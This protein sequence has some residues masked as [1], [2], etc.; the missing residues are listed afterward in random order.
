LPPR[1]NRVRE[2][3]TA[4]AAVAGVIVFSGSPLV[5]EVIA[6]AG[7]DFVILDME[8]SPLGLGEAAHLIR[9]ADASGITAFVRIPA[10]D[11]ALV[12]RLLDLGAHGIVLPHASA[13]SCRALVSAMRYPPE[14]ERGACQITRA[15]GYRRG[16]W[17]AY[18]AHATREL[19]AIALIEDAATL[20]DIDAI[21]A[22]RGIDTYFVG[23]TDLSIALGVPGAT[24]DDPQLGAALDRVVGAAKQNGK[25]V[26]TLL[27]KPLEAD[28]G[29]RLVGRGVGMV[30]LGTDA[31]LLTHSLSG[32]SAIRD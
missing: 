21:A 23:P 29:K 5:V 19:M 32:L 14:G 30:V 18:A 26:M 11:P 12:T 10:V 1:F 4:G 9:A 20:R 8:H 28:Y 27:G 24:F 15:A 16:D 25:S 13:A 3:L 17:D 7:L 31:D 6:A 2:R 22:I